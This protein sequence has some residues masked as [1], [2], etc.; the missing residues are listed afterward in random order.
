MSETETEAQVWQEF[1]DFLN[2][3]AGAHAA[4][5][6][7]LRLLRTEVQQQIGEEIDP[8]AEYVIGIPSDGPA[9]ATRTKRGVSLPIHRG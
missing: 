5:R 4:G 8:D 1:G 3:A 6:I 2:D 9:G 7:G